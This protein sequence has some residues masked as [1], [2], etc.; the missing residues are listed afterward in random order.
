MVKRKIESKRGLP[1]YMSI[2]AT[3][4]FVTALSVIAFVVSIGI[5]QYQKC[6]FE[7][8]SYYELEKSIYANKSSQ[9]YIQ[10]R[11]GKW[12]LER[13]EEQVIRSGIFGLRRK[14]LQ[15][16][17]DIRMPDPVLALRLSKRLQGMK[18]DEYR[19]IEPTVYEDGR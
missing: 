8:G 3:L 11:A 19:E 10:L 9:E 6:V 16:N 15:V 4:V 1:G 17:A 13:E 12:L 7:L 14:G 5:F 18:E 2:E